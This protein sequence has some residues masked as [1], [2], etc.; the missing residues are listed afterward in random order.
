M[1]GLGLIN[2]VFPSFLLSRLSATSFLTIVNIDH[3]WK[4][5]GS[6]LLKPRNRSKIVD[7]PGLNKSVPFRL[8]S[9]VATLANCQ[10]LTFMA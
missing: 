3:F 8:R 6:D 10:N 1:G 2:Y 7:I 9:T 5:Q 4:S